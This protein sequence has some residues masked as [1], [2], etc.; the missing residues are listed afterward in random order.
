MEME[1]RE[2]ELADEGKEKGEFLDDRGQGAGR[3]RGEYGE[4][5]GDGGKGKRIKRVA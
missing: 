2:E 1:E 5:E 4:N 3:I